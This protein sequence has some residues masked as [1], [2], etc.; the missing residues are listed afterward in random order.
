MECSVAVAPQ[1]WKLPFDIEPIDNRYWR[2]PRRVTQRRPACL[3]LRM[4]VMTVAALFPAPLGKL[5]ISAIGIF[6]PSPRSMAASADNPPTTSPANAF[7]DD[8]VIYMPHH[9]SFR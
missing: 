9:F 4:A 3:D 8:A 2:S 5:Y 7:L 1:R 6:R